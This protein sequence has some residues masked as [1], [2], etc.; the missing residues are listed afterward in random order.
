[1]NKE[2]GKFTMTRGAIKAIELLNEQMYQNVF[3]QDTLPVEQVLLA[4]RIFMF[5][6]KEKRDIAIIKDNNEFWKEVCDL[7][8]NQTEGKIGEFIKKSIEEL[9]F[10]TENIYCVSKIVGSD[11]SKMTSTTYTKFCATT[12][13]LFFCIKD[14]LEYSGIIV[15]KKT[16]LVKLMNLL[17]YKLEIFDSLQNRLKNLI[18]KE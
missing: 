4:Y 3:K 5:Y 16:P 2:A 13:L 15:D 17:E 14:A 9:N 10:S 7:F 6:L 18:N 12:G 8:V 11:T 1:L